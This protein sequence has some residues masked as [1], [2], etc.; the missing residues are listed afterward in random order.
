MTQSNF[1]SHCQQNFSETAPFLN[2]PD[3]QIYTYADLHNQ[4]GKIANYLTQLGVNK[5]DRVIVQVEK[6]PQNLFWYFACL[7]AGFI[8]IPLNTAYLEHEVEYFIANAEPAFALCDPARRSIFEAHANC[9]IGTL[10]SAGEYL[11]DEQSGAVFEN[12]AVEKA[13]FENTAF[14]NTPCDTSDVAVILYTSGTTGK[15]KGAM[16]THGNLVA[17]TT[18]LSAAW[19]WQTD[20]VLLHALPIFHIHGLFVAT[21]LVVFN[22]SQMNFMVK[23]DP[24]QV[25][26][27]MPQSS[28][29]MGVPTN[30]VRLLAHE[31]LNS[32]ACANMRL[33]TSG[34]APLLAQ[35]FQDFEQR[36]GQTIVERYGMTETGMNTSNPLLGKRKPGTVG[37]ALPGVEA[38]ICDE[39]GDEVKQGQAGTL[40]VK[41]VNVFKGYWRLPEKTAEEFTGDGFFK[42]GDVASL[43]MDGYISIIGR[44]KDMIISGGLNV[45]PKEIESIIDKFD[46]VTESAV[47]G[48]PH[49]D[50]GEAVVAVIVST[51]SQLTET[52]VIAEMKANVAGFKVPKQV[53]FVDSL[54]RNTMGKVQK[55]I[56]RETYTA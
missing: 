35:T 14:E 11:D 7:R 19:G 29:Y 32:A 56:L 13:A 39:T 49:S 33:F 28:V 42:T 23:F 41:G 6:S 43:D 44:D 9:K 26:N 16:I 31:G 5:G 55:N 40:Y 8:Y 50:F 10:D 53:H 3:G 52:Q 51:D 24:E 36:T 4:S 15:P 34:S 12:T 22:G 30:Y 1:Y 18:T 21:H 48:V 17:N 25:V 20:D 37:P 2:L 46:G 27:W 54:P 45:Y 47:I 38:K